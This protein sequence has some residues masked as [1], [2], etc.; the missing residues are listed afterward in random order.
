MTDVIKTMLEECKEMQS[1][2]EQ[3]PSDDPNELTD[4]L[5]MLSV[6]MARSGDML[7]QAKF[8]QDDLRSKVFEEK[9]YEIST[10]SPTIANKLIECKTG[11]CNYLVN[12]L[13]RIN[14]SCVHQAD[15]LRT[16]FSYV[17]ENLKMTR[18]GY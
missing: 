3:R 14:R 9:S 4:R 6:Y 16:I 17:K 10:L 8:I 11:E 18:K 12:W 2:L 5:A 13:D 1:Y 7:A 15:S